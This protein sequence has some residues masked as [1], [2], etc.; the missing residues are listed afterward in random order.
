MCELVGTK[1]EKDADQLAPMVEEL[2]EVRRKV[3][4]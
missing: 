1:S 3:G 2:F 4:D